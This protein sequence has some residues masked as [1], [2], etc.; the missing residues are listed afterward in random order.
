MAPAVGGHE[1]KHQRC[2]YNPRDEVRQ[3]ADGLNRFFQRLEVHFV[4]Q[5]AKK[6]GSGKPMNILRALM[7]S[8][9]R[10]GQSEVL[11]GEHGLEVFEAY[12]HWLKPGK[13]PSW[14]SWKPITTPYIGT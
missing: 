4:Q 5:H 14:K 1:V 13:S 2:T 3:V 12:S 7:T 6:I 8:V 9:L 11:I 10:M